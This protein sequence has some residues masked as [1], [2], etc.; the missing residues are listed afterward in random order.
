MGIFNFKKPSEIQKK[1]QEYKNYIVEHIK[2]IHKAYSLNE[3][4]LYSFCEDKSIMTM[5]EN[6]LVEHDQSKYT[7]EEFEA[8]RN[9]FHPYENEIINKENFDKAWLHHIHNN[10]HHWEHW[11][12]IEKNGEIKPLDIP[13][14]YILEL[15]IDWTAMSIK[16]G[17]TPLEY[18]ENNAHKI[19]LSKNTKNTLL[20]ILP[21]LKTE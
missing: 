14:N 18:Y 13:L 7:K 4:I 17:G 2:N 3:D 15:C 12:L 1:E 5:L 11:V 6:Q 9:R 16:F 21:L 20:K 19:I 10:P 8:Y